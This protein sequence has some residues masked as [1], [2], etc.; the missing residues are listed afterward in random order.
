MGRWRVVVEV[1]SGSSVFH[2][3]REDMK[4][5]RHI[6]AGIGWF[7]AAVFIV[8]AAIDLT[9]DFIMHGIDCIR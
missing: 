8:T 5:L 3:R 2:E 1:Y 4:K 6:S 7:S 9:L